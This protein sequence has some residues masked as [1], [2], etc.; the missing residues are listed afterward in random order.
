MIG[1]DATLELSGPDA[2]T[3]TMS[4]AGATLMLGQPTQ[5]TGDIEGL[6][7]GDV[8]DLP[9]ITV[10]SAV[11]NGSTLVVTE[12]NNTIANLPGRRLAR[13]KLFR[14]SKRQCRWR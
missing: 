13:R 3:I 11:I 1:E 9:G 6:A 4:G 12:S 14:Y 2:Q 10:L 7:I 8:I 5:F